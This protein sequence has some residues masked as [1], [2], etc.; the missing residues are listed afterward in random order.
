MS[1]NM[2]DIKKLRDDTGA[3]ILEIKSMLEEVGGD[4]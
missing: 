4:Y 1:I 3:G 2:E